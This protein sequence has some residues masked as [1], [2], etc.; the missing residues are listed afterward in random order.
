MTLVVPCTAE[1]LKKSPKT[2]EGAHVFVNEFDSLQRKMLFLSDFM[3]VSSKDI[4][5]LNNTLED[6]EEDRDK[7]VHSPSTVALSKYS[8]LYVVQSKSDRTKGIYKVG[9]STGANRL[10]EYFKMH[11]DKKGK[12]SGV[13]LVY[14]AGVLHDPKLKRSQWNYRKE[15]Q[16]KR[17]F[18]QRKIPSV[19]GHEWMGVSKENLE[20]FKKIV[21]ESRGIISRDN[22]QR[23]ATAIRDGSVPKRKDAVVKVLKHSKVTKKGD[24]FGKLFYTLQWRYPQI[25]TH[26]KGMKGDATKIS[27]QSKIQK[28][29]QTNDTLETMLKKKDGFNRLG[30]NMGTNAIALIHKYIVDNDLQKKDRFY[31]K[32]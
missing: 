31:K 14:L 29:N 10:L 26:L 6:D 12:C 16:I 9:V 21:T 2:I 24:D 32:L 8:L 25:S 30:R 3:D 11:G 5:T 1:S 27:K 13:Y 17:T 22:T 20:A 19:R 23:V 18:K 7:K 4:V 15:A 28:T